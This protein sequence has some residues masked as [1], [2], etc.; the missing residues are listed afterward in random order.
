M[1]P[2]LAQVMLFSGNFAPRGWADCDGS[3]LQI[4]QNQALY[5]LVGTTYGGDGRT[6]FGLPKIGPPASGLRYVIAV[7]GGYP[8][9]N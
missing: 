4:A 2:M 7:Q 5:S 1:E 3:V 8:Q 9:R 6:T